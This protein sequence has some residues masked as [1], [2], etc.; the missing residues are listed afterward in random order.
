[1]NGP[2]KNKDKLSIRT[3]V[4]VVIRTEGLKVKESQ[5]FSIA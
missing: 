2:H 1:M 4:K 5:N 3:Y